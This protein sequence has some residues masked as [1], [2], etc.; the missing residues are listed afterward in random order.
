[1]FIILIIVL[2]MLYYYNTAV[3][4]DNNA[5]TVPHPEV[6]RAINGAYD[7]GNPSAHYAHEAKN[8]VEELKKYVLTVLGKN[9]HKCIITSSASEANNLLLT[10]FDSYCSAFEHKTSLAVCKPLGEIKAGQM[11]SVMYCNNE[12]GDIYD[13]KKISR[14][15]HAA[16]AL[17]H[18]DASQF[19]GKSENPAADFAGIDFITI[20]LHKMYG[21]LGVGLLIIPA[22]IT[23]KPQIHGVQNGGLR[24]GTE[25]I[26]AICGSIRAIEITLANRAA[27]NAKLRALC[28]SFKNI[29]RKYRDEE[30]VEKY[31]NISE[32]SAYRVSL[33][34]NRNKFIILSKNSINTVLVSF[35][36]IDAGSRFCN[37]KFREKLTQCGIHVSIGSACN[38]GIQ[39]PSH[40]LLAMGLP[41]VVRA[42]VIR[43]SFGDYNTF[44]DLWKFELKC[45]TLL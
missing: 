24:G 45:G 31:L 35:I 37:V 10:N 44:A 39:G 36:N 19:F 17:F 5:T 15:C 27:K 41:F 14:E 3:H 34:G 30:T 18:T 42:G 2:I 25:N 38:T 9:N 23:L 22:N 16:G 33:I 11:I 40:V 7:L 8:C 29:L 4:F 28:E 43:F 20:S 1:M 13:V 12:T 6:I 32:E 21:P 26:P